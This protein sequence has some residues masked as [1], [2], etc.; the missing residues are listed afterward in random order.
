VLKS[1]V[2]AVVEVFDAMHDAGRAVLSTGT[3]ETVTCVHYKC[4]IPVSIP[5]NYS[6]STPYAEES[7]VGL[8]GNLQRQSS[9]FVC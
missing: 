3:T 7:R 6:N 9:L 1:G 5:I 8:S 2:V 4:A